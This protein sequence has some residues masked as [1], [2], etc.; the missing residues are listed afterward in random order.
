MRVFHS[1]NLSSTQASTTVHAMK[2]GTHFY[3][4]FLSLNK[5]NEKFQGSL[6]FKI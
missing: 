2:S 6:H 3:C 5:E 1:M 4:R